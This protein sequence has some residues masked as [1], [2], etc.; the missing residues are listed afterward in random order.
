MLTRLIDYLK[1]RGITT[2]GTSLM[3]N[4]EDGQSGI[5]ISS[6]MDTWIRLRM[7]E[8]GNERNRGVS[9]VKSRGMAHSNQ[10]RE[11][12]ITD[13]G[14]KL[15][16]VYLGQASGL[17]MGSSRAAQS[18]KD[19]AESIVE[20]QE[21]ERKRHEKENKLRLLDAQIA[22]LRSEFEL[23]EKELNDIVRGEE[24]KREV[25]EKGH[26]EMA[27]LRKSDSLLKGS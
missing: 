9:V 27:R 2:L 7:F 21:I 19:E 22:A 4:E 3:D 17:L 5:G 1:T 10:I 23:E 13:Q 20:K 15:S 18:A 8:N 11:Y 14:V 16:D 25:T 26:T 6:L 12:L 24:L